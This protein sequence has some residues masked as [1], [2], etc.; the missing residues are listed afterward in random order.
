MIYL[1]KR[2]RLPI[3]GIQ[4]LT[5]LDPSIRGQAAYF[6]GLRFQRMGRPAEQVFNVALKTAGPGSS[7][8]RLTKR[9]LG[10]P[11]KKK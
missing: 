6:M 3:F 9:E 2:G 5:R 11:T 4:T 10:R 8:E 1:W 7:L